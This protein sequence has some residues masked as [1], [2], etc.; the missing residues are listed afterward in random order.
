M[1]TEFLVILASH[2]DLE[3]RY[4]ISGIF[5]VFLGPFTQTPRYLTSGHAGQ[6]SDRAKGIEIRFQAKEN[7]TSPQP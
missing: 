2:P 1:S 3:T 4:Q 6:C 5:Q 7:D